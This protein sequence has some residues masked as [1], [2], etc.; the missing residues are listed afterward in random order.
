MA[1][2]EGGGSSPEFLFFI[3]MQSIIDAFENCKDIDSLLHFQIKKTYIVTVII[4]KQAI[5]LI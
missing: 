5:N 2:G 3:L 1:P 4:T